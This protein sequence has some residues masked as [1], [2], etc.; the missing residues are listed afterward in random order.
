VFT[1]L[2]FAYRHQFDNQL[3]TFNY[4]YHMSSSFL[5]L[6]QW[7]QDKS[8]LHGNVKIHLL[9]Y[10]LLSPLFQS[11]FYLFNLGQKSRISLNFHQKENPKISYIHL[12]LL[13]QILESLI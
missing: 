5:Y 7:I 3:Q 8:C 11:N 10:L 6:F 13:L 9:N 12:F 2:L 4:I 1:S